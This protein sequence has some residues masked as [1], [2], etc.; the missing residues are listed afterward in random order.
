MNYRLACASSR[1]SELSVKAFV[2]SSSPVAY[3]RALYRSLLRVVPVPRFWIETFFIQFCKKH[4]SACARYRLLSM[5]L[6]SWYA[7]SSR[8]SM[9]T[10]GA[11]IAGPCGVGPFARNF[12]LC[13]R[14]RLLSFLGFVACPASTTSVERAKFRRERWDNE[15]KNILFWSERRARATLKC[16]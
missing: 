9:S 8:R 14:S 12:V 11:C 15:G 7:S 13:G 3:P 4:V 5:M 16:A 6:Y 10:R 1:S 2:Q